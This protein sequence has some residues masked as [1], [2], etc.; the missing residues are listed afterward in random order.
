MADGEGLVNWKGLV[1][2]L[3]SGLI[4]IPG[5]MLAGF[6]LIPF[7]IPSKPASEVSVP[8]VE[9]PA[10]KPAGKAKVNPK[11]PLTVYGPSAPARLKLPAD[12]RPTEHVIAATQVRGSDRPQTITT[13]VDEQTG[14]SRSFVKQD[15]YPWFAYEPRG[16][17]RLSVG[18]KLERGRA[19]EVVRLGASWDAIRIRAFTAGIT[20]SVD[21]DGSSFAG[22]S[23][24]YRW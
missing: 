19:K 9:A 8:A 20:G 24:A 21:S 5:L 16:E 1:I 17:A 7:I 6:L 11:A 10:V 22:L 15:E 18:Y 14:E 12:V 4:G 3:L 13:T 23:V 2:G